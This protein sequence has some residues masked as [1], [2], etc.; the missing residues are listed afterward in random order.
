MSRLQSQEI[1]G[2]IKVQKFK[3]SL[4]YLRHLIEK[5]VLKKA[6]FENNFEDLKTN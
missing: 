3:S 5:G 4:M 6:D 2:L 1:M